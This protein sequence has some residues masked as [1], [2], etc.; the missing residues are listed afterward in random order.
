MPGL[1]AGLLLIERELVRL[2]GMPNEQLRALQLAVRAP[3][4]PVAPVIA[5]LAVMA[6]GLVGY[7]LALLVLRSLSLL[8]ARSSPP[9]ELPGIVA[10]VAWA[11]NA[12][13]T[14]R[15]SIAGRED[16]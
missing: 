7:V 6:E 16:V 1:A 11:S 3:A 14:S 8:T 5:L 10:R 13:P 4:D 2:A 12:P 9:R 15:S